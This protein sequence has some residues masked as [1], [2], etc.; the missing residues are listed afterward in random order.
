MHSLRFLETHTRL[1]K[2]MLAGVSSP[3]FTPRARVPL[4]DIKPLFAVIFVQHTLVPTARASYFPRWASLDAFHISL[5][6]FALPFLRSVDNL[7]EMRREHQHHGQIQ[8]LGVTSTQNK[9]GLCTF[10]HT[11]DMLKHFFGLL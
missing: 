5:K 7:E 11:R 1:Q 3:G 9:C 10:Q 6:S 4:R 8:S 2:H